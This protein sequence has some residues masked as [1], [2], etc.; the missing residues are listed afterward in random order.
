[1]APL[2]RPSPGSLPRALVPARACTRA[3]L[4]ARPQAPGQ[5]GTWDGGAC[6][7]IMAE[8]KQ[9]SNGECKLKS[10]SHH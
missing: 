7:Q 4:S 10:I 6:E 9:R 5:P 1:M 8:V 2:E 3:H